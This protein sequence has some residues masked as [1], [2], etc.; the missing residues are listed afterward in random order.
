METFSN[1]RYFWEFVLL[2]I[3]KFFTHFPNLYGSGNGNSF[4]GF[5]LHIL[6]PSKLQIFLVGWV[7]LGPLLQVGPFIGDL[8]DGR[9]GSDYNLRC[10]LKLKNVCGSVK[11]TGA[12]Q[13][14]KSCV[15]IAVL[16][17]VPAPRYCQVPVSGRVK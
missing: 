9:Y 15:K 1:I 8:W 14:N 6:R 3:G 16:P 4:G 10:E 12:R 2:L 7:T 11:S 17:L 13:R 5:D